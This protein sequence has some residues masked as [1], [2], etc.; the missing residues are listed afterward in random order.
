V[1]TPW[2][3]EHRPIRASRF[4]DAEKAFIL[5]QGAD[6]I[7][8]AGGKLVMAGGVALCG[9]RQAGRRRNRRR[10]VC[11]AGVDRRWRGVGRRIGG[12]RATLRRVSCTAAACLLGPVRHARKHSA[13]IAARYSTF[14]RGKHRVRPG[15]I[16]R[17]LR[18]YPA[19]SSLLTRSWEIAS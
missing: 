2:L 14:D 19:G 6:D 5:K 9:Q 3:E 4:S 12:E 10:S 13:R 7:P 16:R 8:V 18:F 17:A 1:P 11:A 15:G